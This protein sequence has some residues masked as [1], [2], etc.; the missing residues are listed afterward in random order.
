MNDDANNLCCFILGSR[1]VH[2]MGMIYIYILGGDEGLSVNGFQP[3]FIIVFY[4]FIFV[5]I[6]VFIL[7]YFIY[8]FGFFF[9]FGLGWLKRGEWIF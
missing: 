1:A 9:P 5:F 2:V 3:F 4:L 6:F 7:F 8:F